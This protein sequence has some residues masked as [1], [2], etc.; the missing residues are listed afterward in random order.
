[1]Q[2][3][4]RYANEEEGEITSEENRRRFVSRGGGAREVLWCNLGR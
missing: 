2:L 4:A 1:M 3:D